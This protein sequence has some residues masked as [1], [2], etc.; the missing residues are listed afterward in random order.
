MEAWLF[1]LSIIIV[2][3]VGF[4]LAFFLLTSLFPNAF[5]LS[6]GLFNNPN[7]IP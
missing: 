1:W 5:E 7:T 2:G 6:L 4:V 3:I